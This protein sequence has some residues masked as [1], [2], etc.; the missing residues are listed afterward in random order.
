MKANGSLVQQ[1]KYDYIYTTQQID[2]YAKLL[3]FNNNSRY[4]MKHCHLVRK[5][6]DHLVEGGLLQ[7]VLPLKYRMMQSFL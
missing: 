2:S 6:R 3:G 1:E 7:P 4:P 5:R